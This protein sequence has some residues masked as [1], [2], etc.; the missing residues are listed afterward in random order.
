MVNQWL[1]DGEF[2][3]NSGS[4]RGGGGR[5]PDPQLMGL[6]DGHEK[7]MGQRKIALL[8]PL[9]YEKSF[10]LPVVSTSYLG[11]SKPIRLTMAKP[12]GALPPWTLRSVGLRPPLETSGL[13]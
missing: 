7:A 11:T 5:P 6:F 4:P 12:G 13:C 8:L 1:T 2:M 3:V 9:A 10:V